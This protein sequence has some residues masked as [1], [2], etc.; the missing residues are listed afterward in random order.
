[1]TDKRE[2]AKKMEHEIARNLVAVSEAW[3]KCERRNDFD[4]F[5]PLKQF[6]E[7]MMVAANGGASSELLRSLGT[8]LARAVRDGDERVMVIDWIWKG[9][10]DIIFGQASAYVLVVGYKPEMA[11]A[12][13]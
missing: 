11:E 13:T 12:T 4:Y 6:A 10:C 9:A 2:E 8:A 7:G 3:T 5:I 1:M